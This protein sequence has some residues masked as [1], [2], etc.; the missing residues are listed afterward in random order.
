MK[1]VK[2]NLPVNVRGGGTEA[3]EV[4]MSCERFS[5]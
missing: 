4:S 2:M 1:T 3:L 5:H